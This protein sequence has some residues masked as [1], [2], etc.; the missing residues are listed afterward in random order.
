MMSS[1]TIACHMA[2][3]SHDGHTVEVAF[4]AH[5]PGSTSVE[6]HSDAA[7]PHNV[8]PGGS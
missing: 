4:W 3:R 8:T 6:D 5:V 2:V 7:M 1:D